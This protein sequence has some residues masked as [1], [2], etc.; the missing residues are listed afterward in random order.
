MQH[1]VAVHQVDGIEIAAV[2]RSVGLEAILNVR[3]SLGKERNL[4]EKQ[5]RT[6]E[7]LV[8]AF[9]REDSPDSLDLNFE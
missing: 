3:K 2:I 4:A 7:Q 9:S 5:I 1:Q 6:E 8:I